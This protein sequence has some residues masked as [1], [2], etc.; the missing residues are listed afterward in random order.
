MASVSCREARAEMTELLMLGQPL[1]WRLNRH[2]AECDECGRERR[3]IAE[4]A[5]VLGRADPAVAEAGWRPPHDDLPGPSPDLGAR[6][7][8]QV[9]TARRRRNRRRAALGLAAAAAIAAI[10]ILPTTLPASGPASVVALSRDGSMIQHS[11]GTE[12]PVALSG[13]EPG[14]SYDMVT[15][16]ATGRRAPAG[17]VQSPTGQPVHTRMVTSMNRDAIAT[18]LIM[19]GTGATPVARIPVSP[20]TTG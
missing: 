3:E 6:I 13:L 4:I 16:D 9:A 18:L 15:E 17:S 2:L 7:G 1:P 20:P 12:V 14:R 10:V 5:D 11:W 19:D 8:R